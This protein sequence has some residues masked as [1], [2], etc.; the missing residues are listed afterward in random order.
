MPSLCVGDYENDDHPG[1]R[2]HC[3]VFVAKLW[4]LYGAC[5]AA[6]VNSP[7]IWPVDELLARRTVGRSADSRDAGRRV[8][9]RLAKMRSRID[10]M[11]HC[12]GLYDII[13]Y[14]I[15]N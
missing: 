9:V 6:Y 12:I 15:F 2:Q 10:G 8:G 3:A 7:D 11:A 13:W 4:L 1:R 5:H 14:D